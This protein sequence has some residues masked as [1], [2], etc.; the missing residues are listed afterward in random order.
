[1]TKDQKGA[2][3]RG[4]AFLGILVHARERGGPKLLEE[5]IQ[6]SGPLAREV[7]SNKI[8]GQNWYPYGAF[9]GF[10]R[11]A[12]R[13]IGTGDTQYCFR[14]GQLAA[15][16]DEET[17]LDIYKNFG[18]PQLLIRACE[19]IWSGYYR[20]AGRME[21]VSCDPTMTVLRIFDF[22]E[23]DPGHCRL[24][25]GWM[26]RSMELTDEKVLE[27]TETSCTS[28]GGHYHEFRCRWGEAQH[29]RL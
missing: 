1:M 13:Y 9:A 19:R 17:I 8:I 29:L 27:M 2:E 11:S 10:L 18:V 23:M 15:E 28:K 26:S 24:M 12:D 7:L 21:A 3:A 5:I 4:N 22:S 6:D 14:V 25:E 20:N 16:R